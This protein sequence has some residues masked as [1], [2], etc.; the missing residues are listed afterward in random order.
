MW[1]LLIM[2]NGMSD[3]TIEDFLIG[4]LDFCLLKTSLNYVVRAFPSEELHCYVHRVITLTLKI[5][6]RNV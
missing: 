2:G 3:G 6:H 1:S 4:R 5:P